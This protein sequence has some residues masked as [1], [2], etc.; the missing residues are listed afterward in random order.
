[1]DAAFVEAN[2]SLDT[3]KR[4]T[5]LAWQLLHGEAKGLSPVELAGLNSPFTALEKT[6]KPIKK[7][8]NN[9]THQSLTDAE[10]RI[11]Q[12]PGK[13][14][15]LYYLST[16]AVDS[17]RHVITHIQADLA[18]ERDSKHLMPI[19]DK[20]SCRLKYYGLPLQYLLAD[21][22][23]GS[24][25]NYASLEARHIKGFISLPGSYHPIREGFRYDAIENAYVCRN[26]KLLYYHGIKIEYGFANHYYHARVKECG[27][28][29]FKKQCCGNK[30]RQSLTFSVYRHYHKQMQERVESKEGNRMKG[31]RM[32]TVEPVFGSLLNYY[33]MKRSNAKG[34]QAAHKFMLMSATA[35]NLQKLLLCLNHP[36]SNVQI[37][38]IQQV[39][40]LQFFLFYVVNT[41]GELF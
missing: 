35:Y 5:V 11:N 36:K 22:G 38:T 8:R 34:K 30:R 2:A 14:S 17:Y 20:L 4:K 18:D 28:C 19:V 12:K 25:E 26:E 39:N 9:A 10:A 7:G 21:G 3:F 41:Q 13:P 15:R 32:A 33:G 6:A 31:Q 16:M 23:F 29:T 1:M 40:T 37:L 24:G 27:E